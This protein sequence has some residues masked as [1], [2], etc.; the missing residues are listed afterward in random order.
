L[1][2]SLKSKVS[3]KSNE[4]I[5]IKPGQTIEEAYVSLRTKPLM[6]AGQPKT[7]TP[8]LQSSQ[9]VLLLPERSLRIIKEYLVQLSTL[10]NPNI[11]E[12]REQN[13]E[14]KRKGQELYEQIREQH[15]RDRVQGSEGENEAKGMLEAYQGLVQDARDHFDRVNSVI[16]EMTEEKA[17]WSDE[18]MV[19]EKEQYKLFK[20]VLD[21]NRELE[22]FGQNEEGLQRILEAVTT[23]TD[24]RL[25]KKE[26]MIDRQ[27]KL[28]QELE[29]II[30]GLRRAIEE[31]GA[32]LEEVLKRL[33]E[34]KR[35]TS[36][37]G[38]KFAGPELEEL[39]NK[40]L[41]ASYTRRDCQDESEQ[42]PIDWDL[43][44]KNFVQESSSEVKNAMSEY[45][46]NKD[47][48]GILEDWTQM[49]TELYTLDVG[50]R[51]DQRKQLAQI[52]RLGVLKTIQVDV[53]DIKTKLQDKNV[54][55]NE[56]LYADKIKEKRELIKQQ[57]IEA[58]T[59]VTDLKTL[60][61]MN[62]EFENLEKLGW[63]DIKETPE[64]AYYLEL[65]ANVKQHRILVGE[66][67][68]SNEN[69]KNCLG[70]KEDYIKRLRK[71]IELKLSMPKPLPQEA[72]PAP[73]PK[74]AKLNIDEVMAEYTK[75][76]PVP[77]TKLDKDGNYLFGTKKINA[78]ILD[79]ALVIR[80]GGGYIGIQEFFEK[81]TQIEVVKI[82][83][84]MER[85]AVDKYEQ[86][87][88]YQ[89]SVVRARLHDKKKAPF[90]VPAIGKQD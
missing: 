79:D 13:E 41:Q 28:I 80:V 42:L 81:Y 76:S 26:D 53:N 5:D 50:L 67:E 3:S 29:D 63:S 78:K 71:E 61:I 62:L 11:S 60:R 44:F 23:F 66:E 35:N 73:K 74:A 59:L 45:P 24:E 72:E 25:R 86:L 87:H 89:D 40:Y 2:D 9:K 84:E 14:L 56:S 68:R 47:F 64:W 38:V 4:L 12:L 6:L 19:L 32:K 1:Q 15:V 65:A 58:Q 77:V 7:E 37:F 43:R 55:F 21:Q 30:A 48:P 8:I 88:V 69:K 34:L 20:E 49:A 18:V 75:S 17:N 57:K 46:A 10:E 16:E 52:Q 90:K 83:K 27:R 39:L 33:E 70:N 51:A 85:E 82:N 36:S 54:K 31:L 22:K